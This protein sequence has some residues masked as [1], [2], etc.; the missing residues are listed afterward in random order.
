MPESEH[1][2]AISNDTVQA[3]KRQATEGREQTYHQQEDQR[4]KQEKGPF[5]PTSIRR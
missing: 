4:H 2:E 3:K 5:R 1:V